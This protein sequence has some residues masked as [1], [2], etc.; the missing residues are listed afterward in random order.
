MS[1]FKLSQEA[2]RYRRMALYTGD[3]LPTYDEKWRVYD[4][5]VHIYGCPGYTRHQHSNWCTER[6]R[7]RLKS[8][9]LSIAAKLQANPNP[10][11]L[12]VARWAL[13]LKILEVDAF[14]LVG[15]LLPEAVK[16]QALFEHSLSEMAEMAAP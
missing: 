16:A 9:R 11:A 15:R 7:S 6:E 1:R 3:C 12:D 13:E 5:I 2:Q 4:E 14:R 10:S 8:P